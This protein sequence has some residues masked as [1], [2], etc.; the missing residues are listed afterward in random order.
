MVWGKGRL[1]VQRADAMPMRLEPQS[2]PDE[3]HFAALPAR[4]VEDAVSVWGLGRF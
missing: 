1:L 3:C 4:G 2:I